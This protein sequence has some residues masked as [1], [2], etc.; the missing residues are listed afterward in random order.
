M[1]LKGAAL[2][3]VALD[4]GFHDKSPALR[5]SGTVGMKPRQLSWKWLL[6]GIVVLFL[7]GLALLPR[8]I[9]N[10]SSLR[11]K[12]TSTLSTW[13]GATVTLTEPLT[14]KYFPP[15]SLRGGFV[16]TNATKLPLVGS[17]TARDVKISLSLPALL[18][19]RIEVDALRLSRPK[20]TLKG[21]ADVTPPEAAIASVL[22][23][24]PVGVV[25]IHHGTI[26]TAS[27][28]R[29]VS[30]VDARLD[31][32][33]GGGALAAAGSFDYRGETVR[34]AVES[35][36][37]EETDGKQS[38][39]ITFTVTSDPVTAK[40]DGTALFAEGLSLDGTM[41]TEM[42]NARGFLNWVGM[43]LPRGESLQDLSAEGSVHWNGSTLTFDDGAF[44]L[45]GNAAVGLLAITA[46]ARPRIEG[47]LAFE[48]LVLD[49]YLA[50]GETAAISGPLFDWVLLKYFDVDLRLSAPEV[51]ASTMTL[52]RGGLT[53]TAKDGVIS[54]EVGGLELC[55]GQ[56]AGRVGLDLSGSRTKV[57]FIGNLSDVAIETCVEPFALGMP[58]K[59][60]GALQVDIS[61]GGSTKEELIRGLAGKF[62]VTAKDGAVPIDF[63]QLMAA[64][65]EAEADGWSADKA[66]PF[67]SLN[68]DCR[69]SAGHIWCQMFNMQTGRGLIT[70]SG[71]IDVGQQTLDWEFLIANPVTPLSAARLV[72]EAPPRVTMHGALTQPLIQRA[73]GS[74]LGDGSTQADPGGSQASPR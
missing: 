72:M 1:G 12:V 20:I 34:F 45:D 2:R 24:A 53:I 60:V 33:G 55:G 31:A 54:G 41:Q 63:P 25:R 38:A 28:E 4:A 44:M 49:P 40:F 35:G 71:D 48:R 23:A 8:Q 59:G 43:N 13:T 27:G 46:E 68:A 30:K 47:T 9:G 61:T 14:V 51:S 32:S 73:D 11:D 56:L 39:P 17:I 52:G 62:K 42:S 65:T 29:L 22:A 74:T 67:Q 15:L 5:S 58:V 7:L 18:L 66:T 6:L 21:P 57:S 10:S 36:E 26:N 19:G 50:G 3:Q 69:L 16:L 70:G 64:D 37:I